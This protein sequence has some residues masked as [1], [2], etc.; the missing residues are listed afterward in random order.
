[1]TDRNPA[2]PGVGVAALVVRSGRL[3]LVRRRGHGN[4]CWS[5]PGGYLENGEELQDCARRETE[6]E[7]GVRP[8][9]MVFLAVTNDVFSD[10][11]HNVTIWFTAT[12]SEGEATVPD[13]DE[14]AESAWFALD[15]LPPDLYPSTRGLVSGA[16]LPLSAW[17]AFAGSGHRPNNAERSKTE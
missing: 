4:D 1:M 2:T 10:G 6:E 17:E 3:L 5:A 12:C 13:P 14:V 16:S 8:G 11:L 15:D 7:T 9:D